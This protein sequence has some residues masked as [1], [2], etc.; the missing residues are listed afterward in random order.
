MTPHPQATLLYID[1]IV[2]EVER[3]HTLGQR[4]MVAAFA[5]AIDQSNPLLPSVRAQLDRE[6]AT[7]ASHTAATMS[8]QVLAH[9]NDVVMAAIENVDAKASKTTLGVIDTFVVPNIESLQLTLRNALVVDSS[10]VRKLFINFQ[11]Q[12]QTLSSR[13]GLLSAVFKARAGK[14]AELPFDRPD[15]AGRMRS[16]TLQTRLSTR[17]ALITAYNDTASYLICANGEDIAKVAHSDSEH[18]ANGMLFSIT[19]T[20]AYLPTY[21][22][23]REEIFHPNVQALVASN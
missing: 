13:E 20:H 22:S 7:I 18:I 1:R 17:H 19:G 4:S 10:V 12:V 8:S 3:V 9:T 21:M 2:Q 14:V 23:V 15:R 6:L 11:W 5:G 16:S